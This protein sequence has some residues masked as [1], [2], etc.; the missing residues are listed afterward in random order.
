V[1]GILNNSGS[2]TGRGFLVVVRIIILL[3]VL[4]FLFLQR[5]E[6]FAVLLPLVLI[7]SGA[8]GNVLD[9]LRF[10]HVIDFIHIHAGTLLDWPFFFNLADVYLCIGMGWLIWQGFF[11]TKKKNEMAKVI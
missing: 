9:N 8:G 11:M 7:V 6:P 2:R 1:F 5:R 10:G 4:V 3:G